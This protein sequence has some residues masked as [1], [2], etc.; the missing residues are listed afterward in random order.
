MPRETADGAA[1][2]CEYCGA[3]FESTNERA[4]H[5]YRDHDDDLTDEDRQAAIEEERR[6]RE[7]HSFAVEVAVA[8]PRESFEFIVE[9]EHGSNADPDA[10]DP[11]QFPEAVRELMAL[12]FD[13]KVETSEP[14]DA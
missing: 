13:F 6:R 7:A 9:R 14:E 4:M 3:R 2:E 12:R 1:F 5:W 11:E 10:Y 8:I